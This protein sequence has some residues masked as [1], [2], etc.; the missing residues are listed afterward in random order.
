MVP[1]G[2]VR[3]ARS[4]EL[5]KNSARAVVEHHLGAVRHS[6]SDPHAAHR[7]AKLPPIHVRLC[8]GSHEVT[9]RC[10][11]AARLAGWI[12]MDGWMDG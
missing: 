5:L 3:T 4:Y 8:G 1:H 10:V 11:R 9:I 7:R 12:W 6:L 2:T